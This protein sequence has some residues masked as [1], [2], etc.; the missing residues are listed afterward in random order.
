MARKVLVPMICVG[1]LALFA[2]AAFGQAG[3]APKLTATIKPTDI[4]LGGATELSGRLT[5]GPFGD[6]N[7]PLTVFAKPFPYKSEKVAGTVITDS[8]GR[9]SL[10]VRPRLNTRYVVR[11][12][13]DPTIESPKEPIAWVYPK[14][15]DTVAKFIRP[16]LASGRMILEVDRDHPYR[17]ENRRLYFYFRKQ[18]S[19][20][21]ERVARTRTRL[22]GPGRVTGFAKFGIPR[23]NYT[24]VVSWC[25]D[26][27]AADFGV[28][29]PVRQDC[30]RK[31][32]RTGDFNKL[33]D[34]LEPLA[35]DFTRAR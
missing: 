28:G 21:F 8:S 26:P 32:Y 18:G 3:G 14:R 20:V 22:R 13:A 31:G 35:A 16:G 9:Y 29:R 23:G 17:F 10:E 25:F 5:G 1:L 30:P 33:A 27:G 34:P 24:F 11:A 2:V 19:N 7:Q 6:A 15:I 4:N 12:D